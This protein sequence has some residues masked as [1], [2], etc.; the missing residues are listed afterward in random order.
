LNKFDPAKNKFIHAFARFSLPQNAFSTATTFDN[1]GRQTSQTVNVD[2]NYNFNS[3]F[4][5]GFPLKKYKF[6]I[7]GNVRSNK[8]NA[9]INNSKSTTYTTNFGGNFKFNYDPNDNIDIVLNSGLGYNIGKNNLNINQNTKY[10]NWDSGLEATFQLPYGFEISSDVSF[11][12]F[13]GLSNGF[14]R[15]FTL[16]NA[17][18]GKSFLKDN[19]LE[20]KLLAFDILKQNQGIN[21][22]ITAQYIEDESAKNLTQYFL[23]QATYHLNKAGRPENKMGG[24]RMNFGGGRGG[25]D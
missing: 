11:N 5:I 3:F 17:S 19:T 2:G 12:R 10:Y 20:I 25:R 14:N 21:R 1:F 24:M 22:D 16:W 7:D 8:R 23:L 18:I 6:N 15:Y 4:G 9:F 13:Y